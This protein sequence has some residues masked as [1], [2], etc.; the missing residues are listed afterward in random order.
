[1]ADTDGLSSEDR[2]ELL[3]RADKALYYAKDTG[4]NRARLFTA[5]ALARRR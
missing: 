4:R 3:V 2:A 1:V 5:R